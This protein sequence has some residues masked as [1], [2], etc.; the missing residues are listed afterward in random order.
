MNS[1]VSRVRLAT[2]PRARP[3]PP[4]RPTDAKFYLRERRRGSTR[5]SHRQG[6]SNTV[7]KHRRSVT[8]TRSPARSSPSIGELEEHVSAVSAVGSSSSVSPSPSPEGKGTSPGRSPPAS[9]VACVHAVVK[10][11]LK[12][13]ADPRDASVV[14]NAA[15]SL[16][17]IQQARLASL[18]AAAAAATSSFVSRSVAAQA[19]VR[20][21]RRRRAFLVAPRLGGV[22]R[23]RRRRA[24][25]RRARAS[26]RAPSTRVS[27]LR[28]PPRF[29]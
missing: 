21:A 1:P 26:P 18:A 6:G 19:S 11:M 14:S 22:F 5:P 7:E 8:P 2:A 4:Y 10:A 12:N 25:R 24:T 9:V 23:A 29:P 3:R 13:G 20:N 16:S 17:R 15:F 27:R 28:V